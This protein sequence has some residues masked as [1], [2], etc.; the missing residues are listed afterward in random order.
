[1]SLR[2]I[3]LATVIGSVVLA[4]GEETLDPL[5]EVLVVV[6]TDLPVPRI[7]SRLRV[8]LYSENGT[9][10]ASS[11]VARLDV[12]DWPASFSVY[13][14]DTSRPKDV[15]V[16]L[17]VYADGFA[18]DYRGERFRDW[19][20]PLRDVPSAAGE[21]MPRLV[22]N[23]ADVTPRTEPRPLMTVDRLLRVTLRPGARGR[24]PVLL[25]GNCIGTMAYLGPDGVPSAEAETC[26]DTEKT[27]VPVVTT[28][29]EAS[30]ERTLPSRAG[31][32]LAEPCDAS[33]PKSPRVC[34]PGGVTTF[35]T[36]ETAPLGGALALI[37]E[38][39]P[40]VFGAHRFYIDREHVT[41]ARFRDALAR[42]FGAPDLPQPTGGDPPDPAFEL[43]TWTDKK[44]SK[45]DYALNC[46]TFKLA[47]A[48]CRFEG[49]DLPTEL[50]WEY[51]AGTAGSTDRRRYSWG[52]EVPTCDRSVWG[53]DTGEACSSQYPRGPASITEDVT[54]ATPLGIHGLGGNLFNFVLDDPHEYTHR[55]WSETSIVDPRCTAPVDAETVRGTIWSTLPSRVTTRYRTPTAGGLAVIV[56]FRC[57]YQEP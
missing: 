11:D 10:F 12:A 20:T 41:V 17:R 9:W 54:D 4:C 15:F 39:P 18:S 48:F 3:V 53:R 6:D 44:G 13:S 32:W 26:I 27:R 52:D 37:S 31:T 51:A 7:A 49:G 42:G 2:A 25:A 43:C 30:L 46:V 19:P 8:D 21:G 29:F 40:R 34:V 56:G 36:E 23:G 22:V 1:M 24:V 45:E 57:V 28:P 38:S 5:P 33:D 16:R 50:Q 35:G 14:D 47:Q 55:C